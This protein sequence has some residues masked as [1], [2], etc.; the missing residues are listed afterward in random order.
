MKEIL[1]GQFATADREEAEVVAFL[2]D[3]VP[4]Y[5][6]R[7]GEYK[8]LTQEEIRS[9]VQE[10]YEEDRYSDAEE[11]IEAYDK[12]SSSVPEKEAREIKSKSF[13]L[14]NVQ[15]VKVLKK[16]YEID[17]SAADVI[18]GN[19]ASKL[20]GGLESLRQN[21][22]IDEE[23]I[24]LLKEILETWSETE[25]RSP[26]TTGYNLSWEIL[27]S[28]TDK[29]S[30]E[31]FSKYFLRRNILEKFIEDQRLVDIFLKYYDYVPNDLFNFAE[32]KLGGENDEL[33]LRFDLDLPLYFKPLISEE[34]E[35]EEY[36]D[37]EPLN[38]FLSEIANEGYSLEDLEDV[39]VFKRLPH[40]AHYVESMKEGDYEKLE[41]LR[42]ILPPDTALDTR[43]DIS[44]PEF[45]IS[46]PLRIEEE[47]LIWGDVPL[48]KGDIKESILT[49]IL[50]EETRHLDIDKAKLEVKECLEEGE[51]KNARK[52]NRQISTFK[53]SEVIANIIQEIILDGIGSQVFSL[54]MPKGLVGLLS[55][56]NLEKD[57]V[58]GG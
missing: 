8:T 7:S 52:I 51:T 6:K 28:E 44:L 26:L 37:L 31:R 54:T 1:S 41:P 33:I 19:I 56:F 38:D 30:C 36:K 22:D 21:P 10:L 34:Y 24:N 55:L 40:L 49:E 14:S 46:R 50:D 5:E 32:L 2:T 45:S 9:R 27:V 29:E 13:R 18:R 11:L 53:S 12:H 57:D 43:L 42:E 58:V 17:I 20:K 16:A 35:Y 39:V 4:F 25:G 47:T 3:R 48:K 15:F 23:R